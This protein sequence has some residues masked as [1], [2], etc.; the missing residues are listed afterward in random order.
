MKILRTLGDL[1]YSI[2]LIGF[3]VVLFIKLLMTVNWSAELFD[4]P[5]E[6]YLGMAIFFILCKTT[7]DVIEQN[8][9]R[10][11]EDWKDEP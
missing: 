10:F 9:K 5:L 8:H 7:D 3:E 6:L 2:G 4:Q 11:S 1:L